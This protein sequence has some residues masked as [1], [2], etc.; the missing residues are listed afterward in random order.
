MQAAHQDWI[1][2]ACGFRQLSRDDPRHSGVS[3]LTQCVAPTALPNRTQ[4]HSR[5]TQQ[6]KEK[7]F[8]PFA[9]TRRIEHDPYASRSVVGS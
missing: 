8:A 3:L 5:T 2:Y 7:T 9:P 1:I 6:V 4:L